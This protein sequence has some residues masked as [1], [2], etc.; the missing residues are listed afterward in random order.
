MFFTSPGLSGLLLAHSKQHVLCQGHCT[1]HGSVVDRTELSKEQ[2]EW[3]CLAMLFDV[4]ANI[5]LTTLV[6]NSSLDL[7]CVH[8]CYPYLSNPGLCSL[9]M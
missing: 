8:I 9:T 4:R 2:N 1:H 3:M 6:I 5:P 7:N